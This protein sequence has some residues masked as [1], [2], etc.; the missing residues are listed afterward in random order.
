[1]NPTDYT[2]CVRVLEIQ[3]VHSRFEKRI[4]FSAHDNLKRA[5]LPNDCRLAVPRG[6]EKKV[7]VPGLIGS[8]LTKNQI[9]KHVDYFVRIRLDVE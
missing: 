6:S 7:P 1:M 4:A 9:A 2:K 3:R 8:V 5:Q